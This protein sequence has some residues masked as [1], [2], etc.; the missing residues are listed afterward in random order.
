MGSGNLNLGLAHQSLLTD[1]PPLQTSSRFITNDPCQELLL[2]PILR[3]SL[4]ETEMH[5]VFAGVCGLPSPGRVSP[6]SP[7]LL[8]TQLLLL[9]SQF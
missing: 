6:F 5:T 4:E 8:H 9:L 1:E 2:L 3:L 7:S